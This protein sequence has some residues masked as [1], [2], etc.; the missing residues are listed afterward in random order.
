MSRTLAWISLLCI[1]LCLNPAA[2]SGSEERALVSPL[3]RIEESG[4]PCILWDEET[5]YYYALYSSRGNNRVILYRA[6]T[7]TALGNAKGLELYAA[8]DFCFQE[9]EIMSRLYAPEMHKVDEKWYIYFSGAPVSEAK[10]GKTASS[11]SIRLFCME[12]TGNDPWNDNWIFKGCLNEDLWAID[13][14]A[15]TLNGVHYALF[16]EIVPGEGNVI[17]IGRLSSP[18]EMEKETVRICRAEYDWEKMSGLVNEGPFFFTGP[19]GRRFLLY[20]A[21]NVNSPYYCLNTLELVGDDPMDPDAWVKKPETT[22]ATYG[23]AYCP[24]H[25]SVFL[26]PDGTEYYLAYH[27]KANRGGSGFRMLHV[28]PLLFDADGAPLLE[29]PLEKNEHFPAPSGE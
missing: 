21:N 28:Q 9:K 20:S 13:A 7:V 18:W 2:A 1:L 6:E 23:T 3:I 12:C 17:G 29:R 15:F 26:S 11:Q 22:F 5:G 16:A 4:D 14:S 25:G 10:Y 8:G 19:T 24:G 27:V